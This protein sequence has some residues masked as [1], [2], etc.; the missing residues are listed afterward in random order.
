MSFDVVLH[1]KMK[2]MNEQILV[3][4]S[5]T[6]KLRKMRE[7]LSREGFNIITVIDR[8]SA[9]SICDKIKIEYVIG[10]PNDLGLLEENS[11]S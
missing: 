10:R 8:E 4:D 11:N 1:R 2:N 7:L 6:I 5:D 9:L 3:I